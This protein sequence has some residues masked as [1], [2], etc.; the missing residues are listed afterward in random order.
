MP[1]RSRSPTVWPV[2]ARKS[3]CVVNQ[4]A[5]RISKSRIFASANVGQF[6]SSL[7]RGPGRGRC[8]AD[9]KNGGMIS[10]AFFRI[11]LFIINHLWVL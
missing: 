1:E 6:E 7:L 11:Y 4:K 3:R 5:R 10:S 8:V 9:G 2:F